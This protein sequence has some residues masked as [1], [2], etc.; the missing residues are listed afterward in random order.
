MSL[1]WKVG[2]CK[3]AKAGLVSEACSSNPPCAQQMRTEKLGINTTE[4]MQWCYVM[5][6]V[7][8]RLA[9]SV[10]LCWKVRECKRAEGNW[11]DSHWSLMRV[12]D[13]LPRLLCYSMK[14]TP[15][16]ILHQLSRVAKSAQFA[17]CRGVAEPV[18]LTPRLGS[19]Q[20][21]RVHV[22][23]TLSLSQLLTRSTCSLQSQHIV[24]NLIWD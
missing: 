18:T 20:W 9:R 19:A 15:M 24:K 17:P 3:R 4:R 23:H 5:Y 16:L 7:F 12:A 14:L 22:W 1:C 6:L 21:W 13:A 8:M 10:S 11:E 2:E